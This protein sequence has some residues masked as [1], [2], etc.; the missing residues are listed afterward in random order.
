MELIRSRT[1]SKGMSDSPVF[2]EAM[3]ASTSFDRNSVMRSFRRLSV[4]FFFRCALF[5]Y[6]AEAVVPHQ[7]L[8]LLFGF[9]SFCREEGVGYGFSSIVVRLVPASTKEANSWKKL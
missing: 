3:R 9:L 5:L 8:S 1:S 7:L 4:I 2:R 6:V